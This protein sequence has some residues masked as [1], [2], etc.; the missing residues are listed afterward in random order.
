MPPDLQRLPELGK[1]PETAILCTALVERGSKMA[2]DSLVDDDSD[3]VTTSLFSS[4]ANIACSADLIGEW[5]FVASSDELSGSLAWTPT[6]SDI[7]YLCLL[8]DDGEATDYLKLSSRLIV[9]PHDMELWLKS[10][11][12]VT[13]RQFCCSLGRSVGN[14]R[15][16]IASGDLINHK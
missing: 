7:Y 9:I 12:G 11:K 8:A 5:S 2:D 16:F 10:D 14:G 13:P 3:D 15:N 1:T 4:S 6:E